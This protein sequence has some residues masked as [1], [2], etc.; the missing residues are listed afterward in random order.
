MI[1]F[2]DLKSLSSLSDMIYSDK[3]VNALKINL[4]LVDRNR[5][6]SDSNVFLFF[7]LRFRRYNLRRFFNRT[8]NRDRFLFIYFE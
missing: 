4:I 3:D 7:F 2:Q 6:E 5:R 8:K 1:A